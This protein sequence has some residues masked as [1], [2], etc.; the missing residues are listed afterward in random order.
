L[1]PVTPDLDVPAVFRKGHLSADRRGRLLATAFV[2]AE[3]TKDVVEPNYACF[4]TEV[5]RIVPTHALHVKLLPAVTIFSV[6]R[7]RI[8]LFE[9]RY[10]RAALAITGIDACT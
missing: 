7:I 2:R 10:V 5:L 1:Q 6:R 3:R 9:R 8:F 4:Q